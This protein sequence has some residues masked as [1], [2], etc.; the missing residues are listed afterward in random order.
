MI[1]LRVKI[2]FNYY[3]ILGH[4]ARVLVTVDTMK[5]VSVA[6]CLVVTW[7]H[8]SRVSAGYT[9]HRERGDKTT[10]VN[11]DNIYF[12]ALSGE[13]RRM[14]G[15]VAQVEVIRK[16]PV[17]TLNGGGVVNKVLKRRKKFRRL[18]LRRTDN[19]A[20]SKHDNI[21]DSHSDN[22]PQLRE[23]NDSFEK[24]EPLKAKYKTS[25]SIRMHIKHN[26]RDDKTDK[27]IKNNHRNQMKKTNY[28]DKKSPE[29]SKPHIELSDKFR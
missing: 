26:N 19:Y 10:G 12:D 17:R 28:R 15:D 25:D 8:W 9:D 16:T 23:L 4:L 22:E 3:V 2:V 20:E 6:W 14:P 27:I 1:L 24:L 7:A 13:F 11:G 18:P 29:I 5:L 21:E